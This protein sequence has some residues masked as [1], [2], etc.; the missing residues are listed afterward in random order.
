MK[1]RYKIG[2]LAGLGA[3]II[4]A[5]VAT[6]LGLCG[7]AVALLAGAVAGFFASQKETPVNKGEGARIGLSS[8]VIAGLLGM[9]GQVLGAVVALAL[10]QLS[11]LGTPIG[12]I[13]G[14][15]ADPSIVAI[16]YLS[17][18]GTGLCFGLVD[19]VAAAAGGSAAGYLGTSGTPQTSPP[20]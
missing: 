2:V 7:P 20:S 4:N 19:L 1:P 18:T 14:P 10:F 13:P 3:L 9:I 12:S 17:G 8:G 6:I 11:G 16:Y 15:D 5:A